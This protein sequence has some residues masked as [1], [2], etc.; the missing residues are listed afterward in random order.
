MGMFQLAGV[1]CPPIHSV[2]MVKMGRKNAV[3]IGFICMI[4]A[5]TGLGLLAFIPDTYWKF[6][7]GMSMAI[8]FL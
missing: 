1:V 4:T 7:L 6:F 8:R 3:V 2:T 5:N